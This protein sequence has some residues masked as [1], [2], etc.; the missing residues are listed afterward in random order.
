MQ[1]VRAYKLG[2]GDRIEVELNIDIEEIAK[3]AAV[4]AAHNRS[5]KAK[6]MDGAIIG[7]LLK[8]E[9]SQ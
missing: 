4:R 8:R 1:I 9:K 5:G 3:E 7:K 6:L 2:N